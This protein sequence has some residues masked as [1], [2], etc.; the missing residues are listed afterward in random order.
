DDHEFFRYTSARW[1]RNDN[2]ERQNRYVRFDVNA[3]CDIAATACGA[4]ECTEIKKLDEGGF[5]RAFL[6]RFDNDKEAVARIP[7]PISGPPHLLTASEVATLDFVRNVMDIPAPKVL[8]WS[9]RAESTP[10]GAEFMVLEKVDGVPLPYVLKEIQDAKDKARD[11]SETLRHMLNIDRKFTRLKF[12]MHGS[13]FYKG[14]VAEYP[15]T[16]KLFADESQESDFTRKFAIGP[17]MSYFLW[18]D[19][20]KQL[21]VDRGPWSTAS[22][23]I[24]GF[25]RCEQE[26]LQHFAQPRRPED[27]TYRS[28]ENNDPQQHIEALEKCLKA[29]PHVIPQQLAWPAIW[30]PDLHK[31]NI[32]VSKDAPHTLSGLIDWQFAGIGPFF[33]QMKIPKAFRYYGSR[34]ELPA[35]GAGGVKLPDDFESLPD[36]EK[37]LVVEEMFEAGVHVTYKNATKC[38]SFMHALLEHPEFPIVM[39]PFTTALESW[40]RGLEELKFQLLVLSEN[41]ENI[42]DDGEDCPIRYS[43]E[44]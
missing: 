13:L 8:A 41:W 29:M 6:L 32:F 19:E 25:I 22:E 20:R 11:I 42:S 9:S 16:T 17:H 3:L 36:D 38:N 21:D 31:G 33:H 5:N 18:R 27:P 26:W 40:D 37:K 10:V 39:E 23:Y 2:F 7:F 14:D 43:D 34:I 30:H 35:E 15:H 1:L 28:A 4:E 24:S 44:E 12:T